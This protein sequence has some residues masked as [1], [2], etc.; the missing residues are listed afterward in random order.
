MN[1]LIIVLVLL[2]LM[3][4]VSAVIVLTAVKLGGRARRFEDELGDELAAGKDEGVKAK[5]DEGAKIEDE[6]VDG[7]P[8]SG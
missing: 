7:K 1:L 6:A 2:L 3:M 8:V 5:K 4:L